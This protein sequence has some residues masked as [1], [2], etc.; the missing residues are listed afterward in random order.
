MAMPT[1]SDP[2]LGLLV[3]VAADA[4]TLKE[5][6]TMMLRVDLAHERYGGADYSRHD[7][8]RDRL[9]RARTLALQGDRDAH[10]A[11]LAFVRVLVQQMVRNPYDPP[12]WFAELCESLLADGYQLTWDNWTETDSL[13]ED[14]RKQPNYRILPT[15]SG[16]VPLADEISVLERD[17]DLRGYTVAL[18]HYRQAVDLFGQHQQYEPANGALRNALEAVVMGLAK[19][20]AN[21][22]GQGRAGEGRPAIDHLIKTEALPKQD[23][24]NMLLGLW[25][26]IQ[27]NGPHPGQSTA[28]EARMRIQFVTA[29]AR[30]LLNHFRV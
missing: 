15:D 23:G 14:Y 1:L 24:G 20:H 19:D 8:V 22:Q 7:L 3:Q 29:A 10:R 2:T 21:F 11:L 18:K 30:F 6:K 25:Q 28:D 17:L 4:Y 13:L 9:L 26:M 27:T 16:P 12:H 5:L